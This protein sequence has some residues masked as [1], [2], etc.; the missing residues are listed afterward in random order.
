[1]ILLG[2]RFEVKAR[3][4]ELEDLQLLFLLRFRVAVKIDADYCLFV[5]PMGDAYVVALLVR[6]HSGWFDGFGW[7][8][9]ASRVPRL[10]YLLLA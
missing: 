6:H 3:D 9:G 1:M 7:N 5:L 10:D 2:P 4:S 8:E